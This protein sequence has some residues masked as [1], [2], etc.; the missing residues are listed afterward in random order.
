MMTTDQSAYAII[1]GFPI[2]LFVV[3]R[4]FELEWC[5]KLIV[6][7]RIP[8]AIFVTGW[9]VWNQDWS[10]FAIAIPLGMGFLLDHKH[11]SYSNRT[12]TSEQNTGE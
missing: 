5:T 2:V 8:W 7:F 6:F 4:S 12:K 1:M 10:A 11:R 9:I 3:Q